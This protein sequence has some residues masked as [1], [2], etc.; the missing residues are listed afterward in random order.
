MID[1]VVSKR[2]EE[3][4]RD[5][6]DSVVREQRNLHVDIIRQFEIQKDLVSSLLDLKARENNLLL[7]EY[8]KMVDELNT[9]KHNAV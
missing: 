4:K 7:I 2:L 3:A 9:F 1:R 6:I 8:Q 5:I